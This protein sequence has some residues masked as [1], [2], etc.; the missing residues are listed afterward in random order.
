MSICFI[1]LPSGKYLNLNQV[2]YISQYTISNSSS[3]YNLSLEDITY[4]RSLI[5]QI[6]FAPTNGVHRLQSS[7]LNNNC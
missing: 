1:E 7:I 6:D 2:H 5:S 4:L 3:D